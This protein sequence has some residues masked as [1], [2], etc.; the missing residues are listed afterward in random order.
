MAQRVD[1]GAAP[2]R[3][4]HFGLSAD[5]RAGDRL[6]RRLAA[7]HPGPAGGAPGR[8]ALRGDP[9]DPGRRRAARLRGLQPCPAGRRM[10]PQPDLLALPGL[11]RHRPRRPRPP[12]PGRRQV[13]DPSAPRP[14]GLAG[15][16]RERRP[17]HPNARAHR[18][19]RALGRAGH[20]GIAAQ[21]GHLPRRLRSRDGRRARDAVRGGAARPPAR[22][23]LPGRRSRSLRVTAAGRQRLNAVTAFL[24]ARETA[25]AVS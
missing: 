21:R 20:D 12:D 3:R 11:C 7:R 22:R 13:G 4:A 24:L 23:R 16:R 2:G 10:P 25:A 9:G 18:A 8:R 19:G 14:R 5:R 1:R 6:S 15:G 17:R